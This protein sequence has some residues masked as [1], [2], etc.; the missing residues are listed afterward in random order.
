MVSVTGGQ[1]DG[2]VVQAGGD[3]LGMMA[4]LEGT[5]A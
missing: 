1:G 5:G 4:E 3:S 2:W